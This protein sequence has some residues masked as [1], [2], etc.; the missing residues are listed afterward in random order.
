[1]PHMGKAEGYPM[2]SAGKMGKGP[3]KPKKMK[4][5]SVMKFSSKAM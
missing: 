1:M 2:K 4:K 5:M 3:K